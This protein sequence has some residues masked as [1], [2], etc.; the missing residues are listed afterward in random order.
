MVKEEQEE[1][2]TVKQEEANHVRISLSS[3]SDVSM[4]STV[5]EQSSG[6]EAIRYV[7][8]PDESMEDVKPVAISGPAHLLPGF[9]IRTVS[10][11]IS[12]SNGFRP[13]KRVSHF[14]ITTEKT[15]STHTT[16]RITLK[17]FSITTELEK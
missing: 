16:F 8:P 4:L 12:V 11:W 15:N 13:S 1:F 2:A 6:E 3:S 17:T 9:G 10:S 5:E 14:R 7:T